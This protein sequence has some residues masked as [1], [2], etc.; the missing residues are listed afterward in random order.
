MEGPYVVYH[1]SHLSPVHNTDVEGSSIIPHILS[2]HISI[3]LGMACPPQG[4]FAFSCLSLLYHTLRSWHQYGESGLSEFSV[5]V[6]YIHRP[7]P[8][9]IWGSCRE[10]CLGPLSRRQPA[11]ENVCLTVCFFYVLI[12]PS[13]RCLCRVWRWGHGD[14]YLKRR[15]Q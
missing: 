8:G 2:P 6:H 10:A 9:D 3:P 5:H 12:L 13:L 4:R 11:S 1:L 15:A 14:R 7:S